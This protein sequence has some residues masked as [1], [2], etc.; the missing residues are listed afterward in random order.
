MNY[1][2][3]SWRRIFVIFVVLFGLLGSQALYSTAAEKIL[4]ISA[5]GGNL[6]VTSAVP[7]GK[8]QI[9]DISDGNMVDIIEV[10]HTPVAVIE[11]PDGKTLYVCN[12]FNNN[13]SVIDLNLKKQVD[14]IA[15]VREPVAAVLT[16]DGKFL[17]I[18]NHH[19]RQYI[20]DLCLHR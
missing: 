18:A 17:F 10:G 6:Y 7:M 20:L 3:K 9:I 15:V 13:I 11:S 5:D 2:I 19:C 12:Q 1:F 14:T 16:S 8:V 4:H